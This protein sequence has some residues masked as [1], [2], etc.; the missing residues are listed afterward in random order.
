MCCDYQSTQWVKTEA[1]KYHA[2]AER[3]CSAV[4]ADNVD[5]MHGPAAALQNRDEEG[6]VASGDADRSLV[7]M[8]SPQY[9]FPRFGFLAR[10]KNMLFRA[11]SP[12]PAPSSPNGLPAQAKRSS[13]TSNKNTEK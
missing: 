11:S 13:V 1:E 6:R 8:D 3:E 9:K 5:S 7:E 10:T 4:T 2:T 12:G